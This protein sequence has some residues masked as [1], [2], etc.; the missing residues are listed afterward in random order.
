MAAT[1]AFHRTRGARRSRQGGRRFRACFGMNLEMGQ[2]RSLLIPLCTT[3][4][5]EETWPVGQRIK[6]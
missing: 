3:T 4:L 6:R 5:I 2:K 1:Q